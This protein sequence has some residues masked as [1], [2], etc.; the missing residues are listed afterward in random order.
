[1]KRVVAMARWT[2]NWVV[3]MARWTENW[4][5]L[6]AVGSKI[7]QTVVVTKL[8]PIL[9]MQDCSTRPAIQATS[10]PRF[11]LTQ[12][13]DRLVVAQPIMSDPFD[14]LDI[15]RLNYFLLTM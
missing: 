5:E 8:D 12:M 6:V 14:Q 2:E 15:T 9:G 4:V 10:N 1:M 7:L 3:A 13:V 11:D